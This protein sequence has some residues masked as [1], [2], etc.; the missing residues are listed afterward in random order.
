MDYII[1]KVTNITN[2]IAI[3]RSLKQDDCG[4]EFLC[5][6][7]DLK[8]EREDIV[9]FIPDDF[10]ILDDGDIVYELNSH[11]EVKIPEDDTEYCRV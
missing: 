10:V 8:I 4:K 1:S 7:K 6:I 5:D 11:T 2:K 3:L 9:T